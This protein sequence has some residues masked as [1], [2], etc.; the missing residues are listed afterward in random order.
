MTD[1][2]ALN[3]PAGLPAAV[4]AV[5]AADAVA[6]CNPLIGQATVLPARQ[7]AGAWHYAAWAG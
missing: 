7:A 2:P 3:T 6:G 5:V 1:L 4:D